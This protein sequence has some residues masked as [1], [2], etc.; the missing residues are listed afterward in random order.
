[1]NIKLTKHQHQIKQ[2][3]EPLYQRDLSNEEV[4]EIS[5]NIRGFLVTLYKIEKE[6]NDKF[7]RIQN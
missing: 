7:E 6:A 4:I 2:H 3:F 1:M 5:R